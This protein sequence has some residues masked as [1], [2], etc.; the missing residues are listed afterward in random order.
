M[1]RHSWNDSVTTCE[2]VSCMFPICFISTCTNLNDATRPAGMNLPDLTN[3]TPITP[4]RMA[5]TTKNKINKTN[6]LIA[7]EKCGCY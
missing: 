2:H 5:L 3:R 1:I 7:N 6:F 4:R